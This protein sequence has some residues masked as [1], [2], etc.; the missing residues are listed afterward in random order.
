MAADKKKVLRKQ[1]SFHESLLY[2]WKIQ[3]VV[4]G[5]LLG[6]RLLC[7]LLTMCSNAQEHCNNHIVINV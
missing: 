2:L 7:S 4:S 5:I 6:F 3:A 1:L